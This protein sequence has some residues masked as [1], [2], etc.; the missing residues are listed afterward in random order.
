MKESLK[1]DKAIAN[2]NHRATLDSSLGYT[3]SP[4]NAGK[5]PRVRIQNGVLL[6]LSLTNISSPD[7][8]ESYHWKVA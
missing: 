3:D 7:K 4:K 2:R 6:Y 1:G 8:R 5:I